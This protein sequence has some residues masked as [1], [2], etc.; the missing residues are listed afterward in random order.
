MAA[1]WDRSWG[2]LMAHRSAE[3]KVSHSAD[4]KD[5]S[6]AGLSAGW[7]VDDSADRWVW[8]MEVTA[9]AS[10]VEQREN[11]RAFLVV[12]YWVVGME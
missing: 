10:S 12:V 1:N 4:S 11:W 6:R 2:D 5:N 8:R 9:A 7:W 3:Q